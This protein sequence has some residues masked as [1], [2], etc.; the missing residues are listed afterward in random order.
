M[1]FQVPQ[2]IDIED[3]IFGPL[4]LKQFIYLTGGGGVVV[5]S[6]LYLPFILFLFVGP[7]IGLL[8]VALAFFEINKR[9]FIM[10]MEAAMKFY[11]KNKLYVWHSDQN[12]LGES[13]KTGQ[14]LAR[15]KLKDSSWGLEVQ[16]DQQTEDTLSGSQK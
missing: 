10:T 1:R 6:Y 11:L 14:K 15:N 16:S 12:G 4:T 8:A 13:E 9:P 3:K 2:F 5:V 7:P